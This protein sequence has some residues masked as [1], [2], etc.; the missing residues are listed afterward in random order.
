MKVGPR[1]ES[2]K[3]K[4][5]RLTCFEE[6]KLNTPIIDGAFVPTYLTPIKY[7]T[8]FALNSTAV[9]HCRVASSEVPNV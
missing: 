9:S 8:Y 6:Q 4:V 1:I 7:A 5:R 2:L 3:L